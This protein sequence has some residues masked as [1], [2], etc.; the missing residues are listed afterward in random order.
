MVNT[1]FI[2]A[3]Y[4]STF[5]IDNTLNFV[6]T[7]TSLITSPGAKFQP[8]LRHL[9]LHQMAVARPRTLASWTDEKSDNRQKYLQS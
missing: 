8:T 4:E 5:Y 6:H 9:R 7:C 3:H 1:K 2:F